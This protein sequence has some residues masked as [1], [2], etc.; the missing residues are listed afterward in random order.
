M[1]M[2]YKILCWFRRAE[3]EVLQIHLLQKESVQ[4]FTEFNFLEV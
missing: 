3:K 1:L 2:S 4:T